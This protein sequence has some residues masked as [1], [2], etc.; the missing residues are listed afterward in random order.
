MIMRWSWILL[1][2]VFAACSDSIQ[3]SE[4]DSFVL[5]DA[6]GFEHHVVAVPFHPEWPGV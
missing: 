4:S 6:T 2:G 5:V 1:V 3:E